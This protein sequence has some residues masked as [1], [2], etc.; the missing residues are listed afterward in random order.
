M[1]AHNAQPQ[2]SKGSSAAEPSSDKCEPRVKANGQDAS[3]ID[4]F[5]AFEDL[6]R[7][8][9][10]RLSA[11]MQVAKAELLCARKAV[12]VSIALTLIASLIAISLWALLNTYCIILMIKIGWSL[13]SSIGLIFLVNAIVL[14]F[15]LSQ[16]KSAVKNVSISKTVGMVS[17]KE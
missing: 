6:I 3:F 10:P 13:L 1:S 4:T 12:F 8:Q 5:A 16:L 11:M 9:S 2:E 15:V 14:M 7:F 17:S